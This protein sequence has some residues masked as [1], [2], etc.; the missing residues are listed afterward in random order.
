MRRHI[1]PNSI[2]LHCM[3]DPS[4][5]AHPSPPYRGST[6]YISAHV[7]GKHTYVRGQ[8]VIY[9][10]IHTGPTHAKSIFAQSIYEQNT[11]G[12]GS[13]AFVLRSNRRSDKYSIKCENKIIANVRI[14]YRPPFRPYH[15]IYS[16]R[17]TILLCT[18]WGAS[19]H[20][21]HM[22]H[23]IIPASDSLATISDP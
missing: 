8:A 17:K 5:V 18:I 16:K 20:M 21:H 22:T 23:V 19:V 13:I 9:G 15:K 3:S 14:P 11:E 1:I 7:T 10:C 12:N 4:F 2:R 6:I